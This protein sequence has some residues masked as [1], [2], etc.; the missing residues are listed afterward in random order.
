M[1]K[2]FSCDVFLVSRLY[3]LADFDGLHL[4][5]TFRLR[6][7]EEID[8]EP[9]WFSEGR[10]AH[11]VN[12]KMPCPGGIIKPGNCFGSGFLFGQG[13]IQSADTVVEGYFSA[14]ET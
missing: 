10:L 11:S 8:F 6:E 7:T 13:K 9:C 3:L 2:L 1:A 4:W 5:L 14:C 12:I